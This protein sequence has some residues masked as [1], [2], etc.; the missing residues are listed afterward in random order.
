MKKENRLKKND[1]F[2]L[3]FKRGKSVANRQ[4]VLYFLKKEEQS[5]IRIGISVSKKLGNAVTRNRIKRYIR[6]A[7]REII[8]QLH[9]SYDLVIIARK[10]TVEMGLDEIKKSLLHVLKLSRIKKR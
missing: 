7:M 1:D 4:F 9:Q 5:T 3:V 6:E 10:P 8:P 2:Q